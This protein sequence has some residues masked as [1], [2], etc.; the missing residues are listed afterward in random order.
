[1]LCLPPPPPSYSQPFL[2]NLKD[3]HQK[4][5]RSVSP[6]TDGIILN[7]LLNYSIVSS[8][9][10]KV[11]TISS[12]L[13]LS[14]GI[15]DTAAS[16]HINFDRYDRVLKKIDEYT[17]LPDGW[18]GDD[19]L[20]PRS[21]VRFD[22]ERFLGGLGNNIVEPTPMISP[23]GEVALFWEKDEAYAEIGFDRAGGNYFFIDGSEVVSIHRDS[24]SL[25]NREMLDALN[26]TF[27][28]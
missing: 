9:Q 8:S 11:S 20:S 19:A 28:V 1:M 27:S 26:E 18:D 22:V 10:D 16:G 3:L 13:F 6:P 4:N 15:S 23:D 25:D 5:G 14:Y 12:S 17:S 7:S 24:I 21:D 2:E